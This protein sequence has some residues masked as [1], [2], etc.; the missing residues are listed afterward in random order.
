MKHIDTVTIDRHPLTILGDEPVLQ[1]LERAHDTRVPMAI[2]RDRSGATIG[3][4]TSIDLVQL[5]L[6][7][8]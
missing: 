6:G 2:V 8:E 7:R 5:I 1:L 4:V 3:V